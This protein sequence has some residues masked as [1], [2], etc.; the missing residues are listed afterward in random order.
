MS[1]LILASQSPRR[2]ELLRNL[3]YDF[4]TIIRPVDETFPKGCSPAE[5]VAY[6]SEKKAACFNDLSSDQV[7]LTAD[8]IV[9]NEGMILGKPSGEQEAFDMLKSLSDRTHQVM[10]A[11]TLFYNQSMKTF[12]EQTDVKFGPLR[13]ADIWYYIRSRLAMDK[14]GAYG[15]QDWIGHVGVQEIRGSYTNV[16]GL[17]TAKLYEVMNADFPFLN[18]NMS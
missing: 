17:P 4:M 11:C 15:I 6:I 18:K 9:V 10:T 13:D 8:T 1:K 3:G 16:M 12:V 2:Q 14:A 7:I 5:A